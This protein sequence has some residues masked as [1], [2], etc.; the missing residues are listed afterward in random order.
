MRFIIR[1]G[2]F[3]GRLTRHLHQMRGHFLITLFSSSTFPFIFC[4]P[5][6]LLQKVNMRRLK[7]WGIGDGILRTSG[8]SRDPPIANISFSAG[9][10]Q[11]GVDSS[12][13]LIT[14]WICKKTERLDAEENEVCFYAHC[15]SIS[16]FFWYSVKS[17]WFSNPYLMRLQKRWL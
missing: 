7:M 8:F 3:C 14:K 1:R 10:F 17:R 15:V 13:Q 9:R 4:F 2:L 16:V 11:D 6:V 5:V 12:S